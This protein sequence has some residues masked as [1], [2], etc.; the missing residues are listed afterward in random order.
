MSTGD[1]EPDIW[2]VPIEEIIEHWDPFEAWC[3]DAITSEEVDAALAA[4]RLEARPFDSIPRSVLR[5]ED[6]REYHAARIAWLVVNRDERPIEI[7]VG[8]PDL[9]WHPRGGAFDFI[10]GNHRLCA[11]VLRG[12]EAILVGYGGDRDAMADAF[13]GGR[14]TGRNEEAT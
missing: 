6:E 4:G 14:P 5:D 9:G 2:L 7:D 12:D 8:A 3:D 13:P 10:D 1:G 11:A